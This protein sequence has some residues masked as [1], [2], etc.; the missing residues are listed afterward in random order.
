VRV[1]TLSITETLYDPL[2]LVPTHA[3]AQVTLNVLT[4]AQLEHLDRVGG[5][6]GALAKGAHG[7]TAKVRQALAIA[8]LGNAVGSVAGM[9]PL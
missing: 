9:L 5:P 7:Y 8:N 6:L 4:A 2:L 1:S 3:E